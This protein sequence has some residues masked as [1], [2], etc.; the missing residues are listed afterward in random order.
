MGALPSCS[1][2]PAT[3]LRDPRGQMS[4][5]IDGVTHLRPTCEA[6]PDPDTPAQ[7]RAL[8]IRVLVLIPTLNRGGA[9]MDLVRTL[10]RI[11][12]A[13]FR[14]TVCTFLARGELSRFLQAQG[15]EVIGPFSSLYPL[16]QF[17]RRILR[18]VSS[19]LRHVT[20]L[21]LRPARSPRHQSDIAPSQTATPD[22]CTA[23]RDQD[24]LEICTGAL[25]L[26]AVTRLPDGDRADCPAHCR[27][28]SRIR[29]ARRPYHFAQFISRWRLRVGSRG[30]PPSHHEPPLVE[31]VSAR[32]PADRVYRKARPSPEGQGGD[33]KLTCG[34]ARSERGKHRRIQA[35]SGS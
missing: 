4:S 29:C 14:I 20:S 16:H 15:I 22:R 25:L 10:P 32:V 28:H 27:I 31:F 24:L 35:A 7:N 6:L 12:R 18:T 2:R 9:E 5:I 23:A 21:L 30:R 13:R 3:D 11:D 8:P 19:A 17:I 26:P 1:G 34:A 33:R